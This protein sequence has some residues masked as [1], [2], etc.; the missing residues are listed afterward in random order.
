MLKKI[1][2]PGFVFRLFPGY[3]AALLLCA[4]CSAPAN[5]PKNRP[6]EAAFGEFPATE[7]LPENPPESAGIPGKDAG[8]PG[9]NAGSGN[10]EAR[11][12]LE[13]FAELERSGGFVPG[14]G[15]AESN[16]REASGDYAGAVLAVYKELSWVYS[17]GEG[18]VTKEALTAGLANILELGAGP[19]AVE[20]A[21]AALAF[22]EGR[23]NEAETLLK[24]L[25]AGE[26]ETDGFS[27]WMLLVCA[28]EQGNASREIRGEYSAIRAR[29]ALFPEYWYRGARY[30]RTLETVVPAAG[31][32]AERCINLAGNGPYAAECR[33]IL[34]E[35]AGLG[36]KDGGAI[37]TQ[38]EIEAFADTAL[39]SSRPEL[40]AELLPLVGLP[41]NPYTLYA[42]GVLRALA[43][44]ERFRAWFLSR[45]AEAKGRLAERL[46]YISRG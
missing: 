17:R 25:F 41:D 24:T 46:L 31:A 1:R 7:A 36:E 11:A 19:G 32:Y 43:A 39:R 23:W 27:R 12:G 4:A 16:L 20:A 26:T 37:R 9:G 42:S 45:A 35:T 22:F 2:P 34:A 8:D 28:L 30:F 10:A 14:M 18:G 6:P 40:L 3:A 38:A 21:Q 44:D 5:T 29:Y 33:S 15:L 13:E